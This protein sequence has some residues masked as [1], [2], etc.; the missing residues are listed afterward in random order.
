MRY[1]LGL[2]IIFSLISTECV[3]QSEQTIM[4]DLAPPTFAFDVTGLHVD[5]KSNGCLIRVH[6]TKR[7]PDIESWLKVDGN[8]T[9][10]YVTLAGAQADVAVLQEYPPTAFVRQILIFQS[11]TSV[12]LTFLLK[13]AVRNAEIIPVEESLDFLIAIFTKSAAEL[14]ITRGRN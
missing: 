2:I 12:Q 4:I 8:N 14:A 9:W 13:G 5:Q 1:L 6:C 7:L 3:G 11:K 10:L